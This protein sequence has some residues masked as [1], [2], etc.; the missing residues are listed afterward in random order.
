MLPLWLGQHRLERGGR[1]FEPKSGLKN[2]LDLS[3][4]NSSTKIND[5]TEPMLTRPALMYTYHGISYDS[6]D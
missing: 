2:G 6:Y 1:V 4:Q 5:T 3:R